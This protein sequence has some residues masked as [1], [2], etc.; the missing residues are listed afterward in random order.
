MNL[1]QLLAEGYL[2]GGMAPAIVAAR[3]PVGAQLVAQLGHVRP[4]VFKSKAPAWTEAENDYLRQW[5]G[6]LSDAEIGQ[7]LGR[8]AMGVHLQWKRLGIPAPSKALDVLTARGVSE[9]LGAELHAVTHWV[10]AGLLPGRV[11]SEREMRLV[12]KTTLYRWCMDP[13]NWVLFKLSRV[14][15]PKLKR[16]IE[17]RMSRWGDEWWSTRQ[18][19]DHHQIP[20]NNVILKIKQG[21]LA[22]RQVTN[23]S[24]RHHL[25]SWSCWFVRRS[26][27]VAA[28]FYVG[29]GGQQE[30]T[31][32]PATLDF[33]GLARAMG[34]PHDGI[35]RWVNLTGRAVGWQLHQAA[36]RGVPLP[37]FT[38]WR[39][40]A[41]RFPWVRRT[42]ARFVAG[43][44][45]TQDQMNAIAGILGAWRDHH[46]FDVRVPRGWVLNLGTLQRAYEHMKA[47]GV[48]PFTM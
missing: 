13:D 34:L 43:R 17:L 10:D 1:D 41:A 8:S 21:K 36:R 46:Q 22:A 23:L 11:F 12:S 15:D 45:L 35:G 3:S 16:L 20:T 33:M 18:V 5:V 26:D 40:H 14:R 39:E 7:C 44:T 29:K 24:G 28:T 38:D 30:S 32:T 19:A 4:R 37:P 48:D 2:A 9:V 27:A 6:H 47:A 31:L 42:A 25:P